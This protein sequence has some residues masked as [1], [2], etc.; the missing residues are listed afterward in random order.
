MDY[1]VKP[2]GKTCAA[3]GQPIEPGSRVVSVLV[4]RDGEL[5][6]LDYTRAGWQGPPP[7]TV[8]QWQCVAPVPETTAARSIDPEALLGY[9]EQL[10]EDANPAQEKLAYVAA[11]YLLQRRRLKLEGARADGE[12][13]YL[14][15]V[16]SRGEGPWEIRD[17]QLADDE[18]KQL[19][20]QMHHCLQAEWNAA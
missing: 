4:E 19:Q 15:L 10:L 18:V 16:G 17:Q 2:L 8:G 3:T 14:Q 1:H 12:L 13:A 5:Q 11:L 6:R 7:G 9:F 20:A